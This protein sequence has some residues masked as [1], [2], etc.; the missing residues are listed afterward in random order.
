MKNA[1]TTCWRK[2]IRNT[3]ALG[4]IMFCVSDCYSVSIPGSSAFE[5][6]GVMKKE[7]ET[8]Q[9]NLTML[10]EQKFTALAVDFDTKFTELRDIVTGL[11]IAV[12][13]VETRTEDE[14]TPMIT[15]LGALTG[16]AGKVEGLPG[17]LEIMTGVL[18][19]SEEGNGIMGALSDLSNDVIAIRDSVGVVEIGDTL[20][21]IV[22]DLSDTVGTAAEPVEPDAA[23]TTLME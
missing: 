7:F 4:L 6:Q 16:I 12:G 19:T 3:T 15:V 9:K 23:P 14:N 5:S 17:T 2:M 1:T 11:S 21:K 22:T 20:R 13:T 18:G 10:I 8:L